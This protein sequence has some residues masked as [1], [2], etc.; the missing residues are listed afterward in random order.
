MGTV[1]SYPFLDSLDFAVWQDKYVTLKALKYDKIEVPKG[2][3]F[4]GVTVKAPFTVIFSNK[5]LRKGI[6]ASCFHDWM[7]KHKQDYRRSYATGVLVK[8][9]HDNG[10]GAVKAGIVYICVEAYQLFKKWK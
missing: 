5:D 10:L 8:L 4:A 9:W 1:I 7:C 6:R 2:F 3:I